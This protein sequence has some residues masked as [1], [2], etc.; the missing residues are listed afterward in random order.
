M[1]RIAAWLSVGLSGLFAVPG[2]HAQPNGFSALPAPT[3]CDLPRRP[4]RLCDT[5]HTQPGAG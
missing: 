5:T 4:R 2:S 1:N 3:L